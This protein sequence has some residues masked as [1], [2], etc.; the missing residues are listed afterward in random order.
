MSMESFQKMRLMILRGLIMDKDW[1]DDILDDIISD[2]LRIG[3]IKI[4][5]LER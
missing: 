4:P 5:G 3:D 1:I 2:C